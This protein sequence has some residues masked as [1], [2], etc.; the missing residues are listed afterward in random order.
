MLL[1]KVALQDG[2][3]FAQ[4]HGRDILRLI[5]EELLLVGKL[6]RNITIISPR[7]TNSNQNK[8]IPD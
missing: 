5:Q 2:A 8:L 7:E 3:L 6:I 4:A 1:L